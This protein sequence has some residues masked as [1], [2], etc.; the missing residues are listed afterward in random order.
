[1]QPLDRSVHG[2]TKKYYESECNSWQLHNP[3]KTISIYD[4]AG[5]VGTAFPRA[6]ACA[7]VISGFKVTG[8]YPFDKD[9]FTDADFLPS[10]ITDREDP[11]LQDPTIAAAGPSGNEQ[12]NNQIENVTEAAAI[13]DREST[14]DVASSLD[15][16]SVNT[17][18]ESEYHSFRHQA[19][20]KS[21]S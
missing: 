3:G 2:P 10:Y 13:D 15:E 14:A 17:A 9:V 12:E 1:M 11:S 8:I 18:L 19:I 5:M 7:N 20:S 21:S 6:L 4:I 16:S